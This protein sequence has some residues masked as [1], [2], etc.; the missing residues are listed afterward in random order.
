MNNEKPKKT[1][2]NLALAVVSLIAALYLA[3]LIV[4]FRDTRFARTR[5]NIARQSGIPFDTRTL[6]EVIDDLQT[7]GIEAYPIVPPSLV[8]DFNGIGK[9]NPGLFSLGG[10][11]RKATVYCNECGEYA[12]Y[13]S[14]EHG[15]NNPPGIWPQK[16][17]LVLIGD[18]FAHGA[19]V[20]PGE[21]IAGQLRKSGFNAL[22]LG[23]GGSGPLIELGIMKEYVEFLKPEFVLWMYFE[24][25]DL[26]EIIREKTSFFARYY[27]D[28]SFSQNLM[29]RQAEIDSALV[30]FIQKYKQKE[31]E[32]LEEEKG[33]QKRKWSGVIKLE[34]IRARLSQLSAQPPRQDYP[35]PPDSMFEA[36]LAKAR[37][38]TS[39]WAGKLYFVYLPE[40]NR[41][42]RPVNHDD[43]HQR[44]EVLTIVGKLGIPLI[45][46]HEVFLTQPDPLSLFPFRLYGHYTAQ[47][48]YLV[49]ETII[50]HLQSEFFLNKN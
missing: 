46:M 44:R 26:Q 24:G 6:L 11:S 19:C 32:R 12:I 27:S 8:V 16:P 48:Y 22:N 34:A 38:K 40:Y 23:M 1:K 21:D 20:A 28:D 43:F 15:F 9:S 42:A 29:H 13:M 49:A 41:Y 33:R 5:E 50:S 36:I 47:G 45:D 39:S 35:S 30:E 4:F 10:V 37:R 14:D 17:K 2:I 3:E 18:S 7:K 25:N 31:R